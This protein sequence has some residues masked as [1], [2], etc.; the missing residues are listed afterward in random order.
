MKF[1]LLLIFI[2][3]IGNYSIISGGKWGDWRLLDENKWWPSKED[4]VGSFVQ[5][6]LHYCSHRTSWRDYQP[7][8]TPNC[9][10][11]SSCQRTLPCQT[12]WLNYLCDHHLIYFKVTWLAKQ[13]SRNDLLFQ[14]FMLAHFNFN[15]LE[16]N[17]NS[18]SAR[19][20]KD[21]SYWKQSEIG[22][23]QKLKEKIC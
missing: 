13:A 4:T 17:L 3:V 15:S 9:L 8:P 12:H 20:T 2:W 5:L 23:I 7:Q 22:E 14:W 16:N 10:L 6:F 21:G 11:P 18:S 1:F 19:K